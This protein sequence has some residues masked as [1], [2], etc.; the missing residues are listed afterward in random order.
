MNKHGSFD[1][2]LMGIDGSADRALYSNADIE[3]FPHEWSRDGKHIATFLYSQ[4]DE[5]HQLV[6]ISV[7]DGSVRVLK[8]MLEEHTTV[9]GVSHSPDDRYLVYDHPVKDDPA[10]YDIYLLATDGSGEIP[11]IEDPA[12]DRVLGWAPG[13]KEILF[14]R[15]YLGSWDV[16]TIPVANGKLMGS[17]K[18]ILSDV[19]RIF[20]MGFTA[21]GSFYFFSIIRRFTVEVAPFDT[22]TDTIQEQSDLLV[23]GSNYQAVWSPDGESLAFIN[24]QAG[25]GGAGFYHRPLHILDLETGEDR[26]LATRYRSQS[27]PLV[28]GWKLCY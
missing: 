17:P 11:L 2:R 28:S 12:S 15:D 21:E 20:P 16:W 5:D 18:R 4:K 6:W 23:L 25:I 13:G 26:E 3:A 19:G 14:M 7:E 9:T 8:T 10:N 1:L 24:E 27:S 22:N